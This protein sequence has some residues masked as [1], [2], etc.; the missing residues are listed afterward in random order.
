MKINKASIYILIKELLSGFV[1]GCLAYTLGFCFNDIFTLETGRSVS[2]NILIIQA[3]IL[4]MWL[5][6]RSKSESPKILKVIKENIISWFRNLIKK[7]KP[8]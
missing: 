1:M 3:C 4:L 5:F 8:V 6:Y 7:N 2:F